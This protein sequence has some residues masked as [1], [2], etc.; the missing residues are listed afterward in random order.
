[1]EFKRKIIMLPGPVDV[2]DDVLLAMSKPV[3]NHRGEEFHQLMA[4]I[5]KMS[6]EIFRT[7]YNVIVLS[8]SGT[9][10]A[11]SA[12]MNVLRPGDK[13]IVPVFGEF[14]GRLAAQ[15]EAAKGR[16]V[17]VNA[18]MGTAPSV[19]EIEK[20][21][22]ENPD[23]RA[24]FL[25]YN[26]TSPGTTYRYAK[27]LGELAKAHGLFYVIDAISVFGGDELPMDEW[28]A[29]VVIAGSQKC[30][31][32]PPG[33]ALVGVSDEVV[34]YVRKNPPYSTYFNYALYVDYLAKYETP[35]TPALPLFYALETALSRIVSEGLDKRIEKHR[36]GA[37][38]YYRAFESMGLQPF[39]E[40]RFRSNVVISI[41][42]PQ[43]VDDAKFRKYI[44][45][46]YNIVITGGF[47]ELKGKIFRIGNMGIIEKSRILPTIAA[48]GHSMIAQGIKV[49]VEKGI[50]VA[51]E[52]LKGLDKI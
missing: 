38:A 27:Q 3:I 33:L 10:G 23:A 52:E 14:S 18:P 51:L 34:N 15:I 21:I 49:D 45:E 22:K 9:G 36:I 32:T 47:G 41:K 8:S 20:A 5:E 42:Y 25:V 13:A 40:E 28:H 7:K 31:M 43:G 16:A 19:E 48:V 29:D 12:V 37:R 1:M 44:E 46:H 35:F 11:E 2:P 6:K 4:N 17:R 39:V 26:D 24:L 30:L 50:E